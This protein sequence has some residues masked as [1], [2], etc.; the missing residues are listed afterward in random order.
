[1]TPEDMALIGRPPHCDQRIL[2]A[3]G[4][5]QF[6]DARPDWQALRS[7]WGIAFTGKTPI[8]EKFRKQLPCPA[9][10]NRGDTHR[11][12]VGNA[13]QPVVCA[14]DEQAAARAVFNVTVHAGLPL[15]QEIN[16]LWVIAVDAVA[17]LVPMNTHE[18][19]ELYRARLCNIIGNGRYKE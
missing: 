19:E 3:P 8:E 11:A 14:V 13:A 16:D 1:M 4:E 10:F 7:F 17:K 18:S 2:H 6:C 9:D 15:T 12:W 5:C